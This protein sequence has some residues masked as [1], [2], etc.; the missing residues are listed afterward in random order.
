M[1]HS[2]IMMLGVG[3]MV[4]LVYTM[5]SLCLIKHLCILQTLCAVRVDTTAVKLILL[6]KLLGC[7]CLKVRL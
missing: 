1:N 7:E 2:Q 6:A 4:Q 5:Q 3:M